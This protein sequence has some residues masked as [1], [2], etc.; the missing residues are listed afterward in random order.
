[1]LVLRVMVKRKFPLSFLLFLWPDTLLFLP[2][3]SRRS[4]I[5][6][7]VFYTQQW[8]AEPPRYQ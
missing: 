7:T 1:M 3:T 5:T 4:A 2:L 6:R 8:Q